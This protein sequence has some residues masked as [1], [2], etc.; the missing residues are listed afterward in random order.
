MSTIVEGTG[1]LPKTS[2]A[3]KSVGGGPSRSLRLEL[4]WNG[5]IECLKG[6]VVVALHESVLRH[7]VTVERYRG[8]PVAAAVAP[9]GRKMRIK[10]DIVNRRP[11]RITYRSVLSV[12]GR[13]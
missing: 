8:R 1:V 6:F 10:E 7:V 13:V 4:T 5:A 12:H 2:I 11:C 9:M 3:A